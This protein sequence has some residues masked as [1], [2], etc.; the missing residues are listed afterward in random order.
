M[1]VFV[2]FQV[3]SQNYF[4]RLDTIKFLNTAVDI[5]NDTI[6]AAGDMWNDQVRAVNISMHG[7]DGDLLGQDTLSSSSQF[8]STPRIYSNENS[9]YISSTYSEE[10]PF[11]NFTWDILLTK[12]TNQFPWTQFYGGN[13]TEQPNG[14]LEKDNAIYLS[15]TT[16]SF[17]A[18]S[19]DFYLIKTDTNGNVI[20]EKTYGSS[21]NEI[22]WSITPTQDGNLLL[23]GHKNII[24]SDWDI[25]LVMVDTAGNLLWEKNYGT[26]LNDYGGLSTATYDHSVIVYRNVND[27]NGGSTV[28][29][30]EKVDSQGNIIWSKSFPYNNLSS[31]S[32]AKPIENKDGTLLV[33][34]SV[35]NS[36]GTMIGKIYKLDPFGNTLW[37]KEYFT[38]PDESQYIYDIKPTDSGY[39]MCGSAFALGGNFQQGWLFKTNCNGEEGVQHTLTPSP[40]DEYDCTQY[41]IDA[42]FIASDFIVDLA[43]GG[44]VTFE[45]LSSNTTSRVWD[46]GDG[47]KAYTDGQVTHTFTQEGI[48]DVELIVF[49]ATCSDTFSLQ[50][51]VTNTTNI[52]TH[53]ALENEVMIYPNPNNG[54]FTLAN[55]TNKTM[56]FSIYNSIGK[57]VLQG[58]VSS[59]TQTK[60]NLN[61]QPGV[62][63]INLQ[64][65][66]SILTKKMIVR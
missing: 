61:V 27:G 64:Q 50:I 6:Y 7:L 17:G 36:N 54:R 66:N 25:Y 37:T 20:W 57:M 26:S 38:R 49:H 35:K 16:N 31:F 24:A 53:A 11:E 3:H 40:C 41:P 56:D 44:E 2:G 21:Q 55:N 63:L 14:I 65:N 4:N 15:A 62:Y 23:S 18:G 39:V 28:G 5:K 34:A 48:Y 30:V 47:S 33:T 42:S 32:W 29:H 52:T 60:V 1:S 45:N 8:S 22:A 12:Y 13:I 43:D 10:Y 51:E 19:G 46:F 58:D 59:S 9:L